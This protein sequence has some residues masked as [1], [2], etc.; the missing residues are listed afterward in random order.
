MTS[1]STYLEN[2]QLC[3][4]VYGINGYVCTVCILLCM[5]EMYN[6]SATTYLTKSD[7]KA[8]IKCNTSYSYNYN[9]T[10]VISYI[11]P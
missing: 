11:V 10:T 6:S 7:S 3:S 2:L 8:K 4:Y 9:N 1:K 5:K